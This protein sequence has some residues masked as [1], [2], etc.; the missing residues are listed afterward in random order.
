MRSHTA[1]LAW[2]L[3]L[4]VCLPAVSAA[5]TSEPGAKSTPYWVFFT[6]KGQIAPNSVAAPEETAL[7]A[8]D[9]VAI[10]QSYPPQTWARRSLG[11]AALPDFHDFP[12][13][14]PY[15]SEVSTYGHLRTRSRWLNAV[16]IDLTPSARETVR[17]LPFV[18]ELR[19]VA[20][21]ER[22]SIGPDLD[23]DG[24]PLGR[25]IAP[26][27]F[28]PDPR[29]SS[30]AP[31]EAM[32]T[33]PL[34]MRSLLYGPSYWQ[35]N[36]I[37]VPAVHDLGYSGNRVR[38]MMLDTG[39]RKDHEAFAQADIL[40]EWDYVFG[41]GNTQNEPEDVYNAQEHG[42]ATWGAC[43]GFAPGVM[44][45]PAYGATFVLAKTEDIRSETQVEEDN[46]VAALEWADSLGVI[47]TS[48]SLCYTCFDDGFCYQY[49]DKDGDT[50]VITVAL[51][52]AAARGIMCVNAMGNSGCTPGSL[53]TPADADSILAVG[54]LDSLNIIAEWSACGPTYDGRTKPEV[55]ARGRHVFCPDD[56]ATDTYGYASGTS[57]ST[58][59]VGGSVALLLEAHPDWGPMDVREA[60]MQT[61]D[62]ASHPNNQYGWGRI[63]VRAAL[64]WTPVVY[65]LPFSLISPADSS[66]LD[67]RRP[68][69]VWHRSRNLTT[70]GPLAYTVWIYDEHNPGDPLT[71]DAGADTV[72]TMPFSLEPLTTY[73]WEV[74][75]ESMLGYRRLSRETW[76]FRTPPTSD[77]AE[78]GSIA[79]LTN[80]IV[81]TCSPNPFGSEITF[82]F[83]LPS[84]L[85]PNGD[86]GGG[87]GAVKDADWVIHD[88]AGRRMAEGR[89]SAGA[90][91]FTATWDG[92][93]AAGPAPAGVYYLEVHVGPRCARQP[94]VRLNR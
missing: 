24:N 54:G 39:F 21:L 16:S 71:V 91:G 48:S 56:D 4:I 5:L 73:R 8:A 62:R 30:L 28:T 60:L 13:W 80:G 65:P 83:E 32:G 63:N 75:A 12:L 88:A 38:L 2:I 66:Q 78:N 70:G 23:R 84:G 6:D 77:V 93:T 33:S 29:L 94:L 68:T 1:I 47:C 46:F 35:L 81:L 34:T 44:V 50:A 61:A 59:L 57:L 76:T 36:E 79:P 11:S 67:T 17:S 22:Q 49:E 14:A 20:H 58:P 89:A 26:T 82:H 3:V 7:P 85:P 42:T 53:S 52:I 87:G 25:V 18:T 45:G 37:T 43:G 9:M 10:A 41:D 72:L 19:P 92:S 74:T 90:D 51:D 27:P 69:F 64:E 40:A 15:V 31:S 55:L 86:I